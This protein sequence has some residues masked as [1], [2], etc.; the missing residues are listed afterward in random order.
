MT[1]FKVSSAKYNKLWSCKCKVC[2]QS[3][4]QYFLYH[5]FS[6]NIVSKSQNV[7]HLCFPEAKQIESLYYISK[8]LTKCKTLFLYSY[9]FRNLSNIQVLRAFMSTSLC[10][11][12]E[13]LVNKTLDINAAQDDRTKSAIPNYSWFYH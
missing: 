9:S 2:E 13:R 10:K 6:T 11:T 8:T 5:I 12:G 4:S 3:L 7:K 1:I